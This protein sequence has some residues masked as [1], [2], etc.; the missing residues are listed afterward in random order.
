MVVIRI[1]SAIFFI[2]AIG[3]AVM[4]VVNINKKIEDDKYL[5]RQESMVISKLKMIRDAEV[6]YLAANGKYTGSFDTL[7]NFIET[8]TLYITQITETVEQLGYGEEKVSQIIDTVGTVNVK[9]SLFV[10]REP[11]LCLSA[12]TVKEILVSEGSAVK[13]ND[14]IAKVV[15]SKG[16]SVNIKATKSGKI[17][18]IGVKE[19]DNVTAQQIF[20]NL[21]YPRIN[22][23]NSIPFIPDSKNNAKFDLF[24]G[25]IVKGIYTVDVF[26]AKDTQP[27]NPTRQKKNNENALAVGS[28]V[29][30]SVS[31]N[32]GGE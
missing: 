22:D 32:W 2:V 19:G 29:E 21:A 5:A 6:A 16:K 25:K 30:V 17:E 23:I 13:E 10:I 28:R 4:L 15:T 31:G 1:L 11:L 14:V 3:L 8:G 24:A 7:L 27:M 20:A 26:E 12:G 18:K 9:D